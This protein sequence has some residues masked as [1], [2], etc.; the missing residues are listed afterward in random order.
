MEKIYGYKQTDAVEFAKYIK[1]NSKST[2]SKLYSEYATISGK[3]I[4]TVRN[5]YY[6]LAKKSR[7]DKDFCLKYFDGK[8]LFVGKIQP[9]DDLEERK[10][11]KEILIK[12]REGK[13]VR[14]AIL[15]MTNGDAKLS[16]RFQNKFRGV[17]KYKPELVQEILSEIKNQYGDN[18]FELETKYNSHVSEVQMARLKREIDGL[19]DRVSEKARKENACL[20]ERIA[21]LEKENSRLINLLCSSNNPSVIDFFEKNKKSVLN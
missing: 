5:L 7:N 11:V 17:I 10:L 20:K 9:F 13:S 8:P 14:S 12:K 19:V 18:N 1:Q 4:G 16:L 15:E 3:S 21:Y 6:A 2:P